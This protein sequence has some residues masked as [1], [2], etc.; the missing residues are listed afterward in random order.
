MEGGEPH[1]VDPIC[2]MGPHVFSIVLGPAGTG[3]CLVLG[4]GQAPG[5]NDE[6][7]RPACL[8]LCPQ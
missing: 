7:T 6:V 5:L 2:T 3:A 8:E 1:A 4:T